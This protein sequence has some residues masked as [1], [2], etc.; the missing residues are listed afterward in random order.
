MVEQASPR[1]V[2]E[3]VTRI[4]FR[5]L[6]VGGVQGGWP[7]VVAMAVAG[8]ATSAVI[9]GLL[10]WGRDRFVAVHA[11][12]VLGLGVCY[13]RWAGIGVRGQLR[14]RWKAGLAGGLVIGALLARHVLALPGPRAPDDPAPVAHLGW[15]GLVYGT[16]D[17][18]LLSILPVLAVYG[19]EPAERMRRPGYRLRAGGR[20]LLASLLVTA[21]YHLGFPEFRGPALVQPLIGNGVVTAGYLLTGNPLTPTVAH[22][23]LHGAAVLRGPEATVQLPPH[24]VAVDGR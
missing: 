13:G 8:A 12:V 21:T 1:A 15:L 20:A 19:S 11:T 6:A 23:L 2:G 9:A 5:H 7:W 24:G 22:V 17:A 16:A 4:T 18:V 10:G 3:T 14:R